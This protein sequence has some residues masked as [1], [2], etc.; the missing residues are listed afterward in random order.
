MLAWPVM[1][2][3]LL[4]LLLATAVR[5]DDVHLLNDIPVGT[6]MDEGST[7]VLLWDWD[8]DATGVGKLNMYSFSASS[9]DDSVT[10]VLEGL[11]FLPSTPSYLPFHGHHIPSN[12]FLVIFFLPSIMKKLTCH[13]CRKSQPNNGPLP[14]DRESPRRP[15]HPRLVL[16]ARHKLQRRLQHDIR[17]VLHDQGIT[18]DLHHLLLFH[19]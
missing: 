1:F 14:L 3:P 18:S 15:G 10:Y 17:P 8:G 5:G 2:A 9:L 13:D 19:N 4:L 16:P 12:S 7:F 11:S 6:V